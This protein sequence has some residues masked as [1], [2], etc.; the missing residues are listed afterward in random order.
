MGRFEEI[1]LA[2]F[3]VQ[4][5]GDVFPT[6]ARLIVQTR[7]LAQRCHRAL[8][9]SPQRANRLD[10][11]PILIR[12]AVLFT[13]MSPEKHERG[14]SWIALNSDNAK[15]PWQGGGLHYMGMSQTD[16][17]KINPPYRAITRKITRL[18]QVLR[19]MG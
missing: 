16:L 17:N 15:D 6:H 9:R 2:R 4:N 7:Q 10:Q 1:P 5:A 13:M 18:K 3:A 12:L 19:E 8:A 11:G 14:P